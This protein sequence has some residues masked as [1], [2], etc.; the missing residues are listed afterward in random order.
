MS[1]LTNQII[2]QYVLPMNQDHR[3]H[4]LLAFVTVKST[5]V[6]YLGIR[7]H[8]ATYA[9]VSDVSATFIRTKAQVTRFSRGNT[10]VDDDD[11]RWVALH[12]IHHTYGNHGLASNVEFVPYIEH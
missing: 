4:S 12:S 5:V 7:N 6:D 3:R 8:N 2:V 1:A 9:C 10:S 11:I